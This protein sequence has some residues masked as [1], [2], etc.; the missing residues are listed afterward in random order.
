MAI[1]MISH[2]R[3]YQYIRADKAQGGTLYRQP[4]H[5]LKHRKRPVGGK[6]AIIPD[7]VC[8][9][10]QPDII[11]K[12]QRFGDWQVDTIVGSENKGAVLMVTER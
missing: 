3:I 4:R 8:I 6:K 2:E 7:K 10:L 12:R 9:D 11:N 1:P 5:C